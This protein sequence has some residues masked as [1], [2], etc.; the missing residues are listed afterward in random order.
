MKQWKG[1]KLAFFFLIPY[2]KQALQGLMFCIFWSLALTYK[3][4]NKYQKTKVSVYLSTTLL[5]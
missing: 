4:L 2:T 3:F 1:K 5:A